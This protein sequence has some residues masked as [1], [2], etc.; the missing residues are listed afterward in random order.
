M[1]QPEMLLHEHFIRNKNI[2]LLYLLDFSAFAN[3][4]K[5]CVFYI[6]VEYLRHFFKIKKAAIFSNIPRLYIATL[7][8]SYSMFI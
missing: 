7:F 8:Y 3:R 5:W 6:L 4:L 1:N 2:A